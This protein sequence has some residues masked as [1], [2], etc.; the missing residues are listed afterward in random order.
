MKSHLFN[1]EKIQFYLGT[2][3]GYIISFSF[4]N[5]LRELTSEMN[6]TCFQEDKILVGNTEVS[7]LVLVEHYDAL[8][9]LCG[10]FF[11]FLTMSFSY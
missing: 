11:Q 10:N 3:T 5:K 4:P 7:N 2:E 1:S 6:I 8:L 9:F